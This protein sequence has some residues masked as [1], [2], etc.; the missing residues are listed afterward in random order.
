[1]I[2]RFLKLSLILF[3]GSLSAQ[4]AYHVYIDADYS[5]NTSSAR[6]IELGIRTAFEE[7]NWK[8]NSYTVKLIPLDHHGSTPRSKANLEKALND[9][10]LLAVYGG[11]H[12]PPLIANRDFINDNHILTLVPWAAATPITRP[13]NASNWIFRLSVDDSKA[14]NFL[15]ENL[16]RA[17]F[18]KP[19]LLLENTGWGRANERTMMNALSRRSMNAA[20]LDFFNWNISS[21]QA[22]YLLEKV[23][24]S[25]ADS[26]LFVGNTPEGVTISRALLTIEQPLN[27]P[28][29]SH[30]GITG[31]NYAEQI[32]H[33]NLAGLNL[34]FIQTSF[35]FFDS[36]ITPLSSMVL[37]HAAQQLK[38]PVA[39]NIIRPQTGFVHAYDMTKLLINAANSSALT[40]DAKKDKETIKTRLENLNTPIKGLIKTYQNPFSKYDVSNADAHEALTEED[41]SLAN[42]DAHGNIRLINKAD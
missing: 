7:S 40:G 26:L 6:S 17:G 9:P 13:E 14:G 18:S 19:F 12:S 22:R 3:C 36:P 39:P 29:Y 27:L 24:L 20:G 23:R 41:F 42:F 1:M 28:I 38:L 31:G 10:N 33:D 2:K 30:W 15:V 5:N 4:S 21:N 37:S 32:G 16:Y 8:L 34:V 25:G 35:N 11:L